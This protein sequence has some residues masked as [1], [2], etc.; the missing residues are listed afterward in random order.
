MWIFNT[1]GFFSVVKHRDE[2]DFMLVRCRT[3]SDAESFAKFCGFLP[4]A[5]QEDEKADYRW[6][7]KAKRDDVV[8]FVGDAVLKIDYDTSV[9]DALDQ[10]D[11]VRHRAMLKVWTAMMA[12]Q[13]GE[14]PWHAI[15]EDD[16]EFTAGGDVPVAET[17]EAWEKAVV[18]TD[19]ENDLYAAMSRAFAEMGPRAFDLINNTLDDVIEEMADDPADV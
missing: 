9:K 18:E 4:D 11:P 14:Q 1:T 15:Y 6:R 16:A 8:R 5:V 7:V 12:L 10:G 3:K 2:G 19:V 13:D 17:R